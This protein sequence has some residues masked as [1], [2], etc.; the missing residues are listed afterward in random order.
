MRKRALQLLAQVRPRLNALLAARLIEQTEWR[1][2]NSQILFTNGGAQR[3]HELK[4]KAAPLLRRTTIPI[5][6]LIDIR[7]EELLRQV[8]IPTMQLHPIEA[9]FDSSLCSLAVVLNCALDVFDAEFD[10]RV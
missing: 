6:P 10:W 2:A 8:S 9:R 3:I 1:E 4:H 7:A 5:R